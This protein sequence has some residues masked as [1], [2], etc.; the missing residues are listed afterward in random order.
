VGDAAAASIR[1]GFVLVQSILR[2]TRIP[3]NA[4]RASR[5][6]GMATDEPGLGQAAASTP[7]TTPRTE[8][9]HSNGGQ[10]KVDSDRAGT[11]HWHATFEV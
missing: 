10:G 9:G 7:H 3:C 8:S 1:K 4:M 11:V 2:R 6:L 5:A